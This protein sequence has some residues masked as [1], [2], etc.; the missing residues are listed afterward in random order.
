ML[1]D[2]EFPIE[3]FNTMT[4]NGTAGAAIEKVMADI[5]PV[6]AYFVERNGKRGCTLIV[7]VPEPSHIPTIAEP[8]FLMFNASVQ[9]HATMTPEDLA[10][11]GLDELGKK[12][13]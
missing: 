7:E 11:A 5:K 13:K 3:P 9:F 8:L 2:A 1:V 10:K 6:A 12:Y 4:K